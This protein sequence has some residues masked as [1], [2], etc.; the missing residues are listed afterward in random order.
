MKK[1]ADGFGTDEEYSVSIFLGEPGNAMV[2]SGVRSLVLAEDYLVIDAGSKGRLYASYDAV[3]ALA[4][5][6]ADA[7]H[8]GGASVGFE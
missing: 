6:L 3:H 4:E 2:V 1:R 7:T 8:A 5:K